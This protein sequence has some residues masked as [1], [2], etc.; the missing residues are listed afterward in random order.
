[1]PQHQ[2]FQAQDVHGY[3]LDHGKQVIPKNWDV[4]CSFPASSLSAHNGRMDLQPP[5]LPVHDALAPFFLYSP[6]GPPSSQDA[7]LPLE[8]PPVRDLTH[9]AYQIWILVEVFLM[10]W[11]QSH[12]STDSKVKTRDK[13]NEHFTLNQERESWVLKQKIGGSHWALHIW[14]WEQ[15]LHV[16]DTQITH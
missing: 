4:P 15:R 9:M 8:L 2:L 16:V 14:L 10:E 13:S 5:A 3:P 7:F 6:V 11:P 1:M 12:M